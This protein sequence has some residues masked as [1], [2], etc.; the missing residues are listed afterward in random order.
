METE[1]EGLEGKGAYE[2]LEGLVGLV[3]VGA[4][5]PPGRH[6]LQLARHAD[7]PSSQEEGRGVGR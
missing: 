6:A 7:Q 1:D 5:N 4:V 3:V 2:G